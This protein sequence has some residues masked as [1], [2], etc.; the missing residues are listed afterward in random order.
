MMRL[1]IGKYG[2]SFEEV[3]RRGWE[4]DVLLRRVGLMPNILSQFLSG[5]CGKRKPFWKPSVSG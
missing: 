5:R 2:M 3:K 1:G 4:V